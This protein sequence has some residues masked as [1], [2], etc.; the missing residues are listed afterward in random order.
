MVGV[1]VLVEVAGT[2][3][4]PEANLCCKIMALLFEKKIA[5]V[6]MAG[7][8]EEVKEVLQHIKEA[9]L[10]PAI[11]VVNTFGAK[12]ILPALDPLIGELPVLYLR[13]QLF[14][15]KSG[16]MDRLLGGEVS[17]LQTSTVL[18]HMTPRLTSMWFYG[19]KNSDVVAKRAAGALLRFL[20]DGEFRHIEA[21]AAAGGTP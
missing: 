14:A 4:T 15:G 13:R 18:S 2:R 21:G 1:P 12:D 19:S 6:G 20:E 5:P 9:G 17:V 3:E 8:V 11:F 10:A 7:T 16:L